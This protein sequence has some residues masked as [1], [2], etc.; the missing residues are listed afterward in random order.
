[1]ILMYRQV[2]VVRLMVVQKQKQTIMNV[3]QAMKDR[4]VVI[5]LRSRPRA[6]ARARVC[7]CVCVCVC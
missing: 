2:V 6:R 7:V 1:M 3:T 5:V 4:C